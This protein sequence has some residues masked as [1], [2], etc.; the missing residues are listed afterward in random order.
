MT[1][2]EFNRMN[3]DIA[4]EELQ[5]CCGATRWVDKM[6]SGRPF[7]SV[8]QLLDEAERVWLSLNDE[9]CREAFAHHPKIGDLTSLRKKFA[10]TAQWAA[11]EQAGV[12]SASEEVL[13]RLGG[14]NELYE[15]KFGYI[16]IVCATGKSAEEMCGLLYERLENNPAEEIRIAAGEQ[17]K[18]TRLRL[19]KMFQ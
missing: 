18:I 17:A 8:E 19:Q 15:Q 12:S 10:S 9:D 2:G 4:R 14:G 6:L 5:R 16:F 1:L 3:P 13:I 7:D 11:G